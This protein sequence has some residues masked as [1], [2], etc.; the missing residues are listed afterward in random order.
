MT[1]LEKIKKIYSDAR[2]Q[3]ECI[4]K[5]TQRIK[6]FTEHFSEL[7]TFYRSC[8][9]KM[10]D[11]RNM[12]DKGLNQL[13]AVTP[14]TEQAILHHK[15]S[16]RFCVAFYELLYEKLAVGFDGFLCAPPHDEI[17]G[18][19]ANFPFMLTSYSDSYFNSKWSEAIKNPETVD[20]EIKRFRD[21]LHAGFLAYGID[22]AR[23]CEERMKLLRAL[24]YPI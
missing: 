19:C 4:L 2:E 10:Q 13:F 6:G 20:K 16:V 14:P 24:P 3:Y 22:N 11:A 8:E 23:K 1:V 17:F 15:K 9:K 7:T 21:R 12:V 5:K 18:I